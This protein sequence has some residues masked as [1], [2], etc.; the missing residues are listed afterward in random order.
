MKN[1]STFAGIS[2]AAVLVLAACGSGSPISAPDAGGHS[3]NSNPE[4]F[5]AAAS[6][7][8]GVDLIWAP[9][10]G[11][12]GFL[13]E[14]KYGDGEFFEIAQ[15]SAN[16]NAYAHFVVPKSSEITYRLSA[17]TAGSNQQIGTS[18]V[19]LPELV[20]NPL[21]V[22]EV[23]PFAPVVSG[24]AVDFSA[25]PTIDPQNP[26]P[27]AMATVSAFYSGVAE[28][29]DPNNPESLLPDI[30]PVSVV[31]EIGTEGGSLSLTDP[32][33]VSYTLDVPANLIE[34]NVVLK[35]DPIQSIPSLPFGAYLSAVT[36]SPPES[37]YDPLKLTFTLPEGMLSGSETVVAFIGS[38]FNQELSMTP[39]FR[40]GDS[41]L[42]NVFWGDL[43]GIAIASR[44]GVLAQAARI[45]TDAGEQIAQQIAVTQALSDDPGPE[46]FVSIMN[47]VFAGLF[48]V[49][50]Q[51]G[52]LPTRA[53]G[54]AAPAR[55]GGSISGRQLWSAIS[56][57]Q[58]AWDLE[59]TNELYDR[60]INPLAID[61][62]GERIAVIA[63]LAAKTKAF[64]DTHTGCRTRDEFYAE[65]LLSL[66]WDPK[67]SFQTTFS[68][69]YFTH[70]GRPPRLKNC[71]YELQIVSST[72][73]VD[74]ETGKATMRV[75][76]NPFPLTVVSRGEE[77]FLRGGGLN[78]GLVFY[79]DFR[80]L[81]K[82]CPP[83][84]KV[85]APDLAYLYI[86]QLKPI[87]DLDLKVTD[88]QL[89]H[90]LGDLTVGQQVT[91]ATFVNY[92]AASCEL[93]T[94]AWGSDMADLWTIGLVSMH[95]P[96]AFHDEWVIAGEDS[97]IA[98]NQYSGYKLANM[99]EDMHMVLTVTQEQ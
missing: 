16:E 57:L 76:T 8:V 3:T 87:F 18:T 33:G 15:L 48:Q 54:L 56:A 71:T 59:D 42:V 35:L 58:K 29:F 73:I 88:F 26:D 11:A 75:H 78:G 89:K 4:A 77:V 93:G 68:N 90:V 17:V 98:I 66:L 97:Y 31:Q 7:A 91:G 55:Q 13:L 69:A 61:L 34:E 60:R 62:T 64:L 39:V 51:T 38:S 28:G 70:Y 50:D 52:S 81:W 24:M 23:N 20:P 5:S 32:N 27:N 9:V 1:K 47:Q 43:V 37:F 41:F 14:G 86:A 44:E 72:R 92:S 53:S 99:T 80:F 36:I 85:P 12:T 40:Q 67:G 22:S 84:Q 96:R 46:G 83:E 65:A 95:N 82:I 63:E 6:T 49:V 79:D 94:V 74:D 10:G 25:I 19:T 30:V 2:F 21:V 45:P